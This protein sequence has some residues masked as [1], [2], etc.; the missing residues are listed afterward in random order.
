M[1]W[2]MMTDF[3]CFTN[4]NCSTWCD[5]GG[6]AWWDGLVHSN[7]AVVL[8]FVAVF[9]LVELVVWE[10]LVLMA[11][12]PGT[13]LVAAMEARLEG[14]ARKMVAQRRAR[15]RIGPESPKSQQ[16]GVAGGQSPSG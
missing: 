13:V 8:I 14:V 2:Q 11:I 4:H 15:R 16:L 3:G 7:F 10:V 12:V 6:Q 1:Q 5:E 9:S